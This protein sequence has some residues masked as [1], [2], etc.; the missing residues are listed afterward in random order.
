MRYVYSFNELYFIY[1]EGKIVYICNPSSCIEYPIYSDN[2][3]ESDNFN[4][5]LFP[6]QVT[7]FNIYRL[8][9]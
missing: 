4:N 1:P 2:N 9:N 7:D 8:F 5:K 6:K 3:K